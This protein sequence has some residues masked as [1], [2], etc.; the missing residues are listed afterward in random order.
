VT[1][2]MPA[3]GGMNR[4]RRRVCDDQHEQWL[5]FLAKLMTIWVQLHGVRRRSGPDIRVDLGDRVKKVNSSMQLT[6]AADYGVRVM[7]ALAGMPEGGRESLGGLAESTGAPES[8]LSK[9]LQALAHAGLVSSRRG[10]GGG[11][12]MSQGGRNASMRAVIEAIDGPIV[13]NVCL[14]DGR[15]CQRAAWCPAHPVWVQAQQAMM[16]VLESAR[17]GELATYKARRPTGEFAEFPMFGQCD[18]VAS[19]EGLETEELAAGR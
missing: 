17:I 18:C 11:F 15:D 2:P 4:V 6:R 1:L 12:E 13:L 8:F 5:L 3:M 16:A 7:I 10:L 19:S 9:V 14:A